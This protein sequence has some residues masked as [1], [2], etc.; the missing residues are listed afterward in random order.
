MLSVTNAT[1]DPALHTLRPRPLRRS[2]PQRRP[3]PAKELVS[4]FGHGPHTCPGRHRFS[5]LV[6]RLTV[7]SLFDR[8]ERP[9]YPDAAEPKRRQLG[10]VARSERPC[11]LRYTAPALG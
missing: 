3:L 1:A 7:R 9:L 10:G 4:T 5:I 6:I 8:Y 11:A 2:P